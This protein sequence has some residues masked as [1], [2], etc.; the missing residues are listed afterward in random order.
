MDRQRRKPGRPATLC[1]VARITVKLDADTDAALTRLAER[2]EAEKSEV[3][4]RAIREANER[5][6]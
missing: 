6:V 3:V 5:E 4:R 2:L 1:T